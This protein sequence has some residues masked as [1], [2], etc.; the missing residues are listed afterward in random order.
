MP[1]RV[2]HFGLGSIGCAVARQVAGRQGLKIVG[3]I[4]VDPAKV[5]CDVGEVV[6]LGRKVG[7]RVSPDAVVALKKTKSDV[8]ALCTSS[9]L[10]EVLPQIETVLKA[11]VPIVST[12]EELS[13]PSLS[14]RRAARKIDELARRAKVAVLGTGINPGFVMDTLPIVLTGVCSRVDSIEIDRVQDARTRRLPFQL[15]IGAGLTREHFQKRVKA[16]EVGHVGLAESISMI[17]NAL[18]WKLQRMT[19]VIEPKIATETVSS[20]FLTVDPGYVCGIMQRGVGYR[21][22]RPV[23]TL[24]FEAYLAARESYD[25]VLIR[26]SPSLSMRIAGGVPG[27][28]ATASIVVNSIPKVVAAS[29]G[30]HTMLDLPI[31]SRF[32]ARR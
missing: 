32:G 19:D 9:S 4:D 15:K 1:I 2:M 18:G 6:G 26:G 25:A 29:P 27:D 3:G 12:T 28:I 8:V 22:G 11:K 30:L 20:E 31:P 14:N 24:R 23:I 10:E 17:A 5:G 13:Y 21:N 7:V 16:R